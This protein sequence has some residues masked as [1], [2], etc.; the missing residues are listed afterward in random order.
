[1][2]RLLLSLTPQL[3]GQWSGANSI[4]IYAVEYFSMVGISGSSEKLL[5]TAIL[6]LVKF[7]SALLC[8]VFL[9]DAFG[10]KRSLTMGITIQFVAMLYMGIFLSIDSSVGDE[11]ASQSPSQH[12]AAVGAIVMSIYHILNS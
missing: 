5:A 9:V 12:R 2:S 8:A 3:L 10:R 1:M 7:L 4:T 11:G 6:G